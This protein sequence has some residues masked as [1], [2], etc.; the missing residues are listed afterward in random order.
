M[1]L[2]LPLLYRECTKQKWLLSGPL[3][4]AVVLGI[5]FFLAS[6]QG[7]LANNV[8]LTM[9][10]SGD[11]DLT[12]LGYGASPESVAISVAGMLS[13]T[14]SFL[15]LAKALLTATRLEQ[16]DP[17][18]AVRLHLFKL[19]FAF[20]I[21]P[22]SCLPLLG[23][24]HYLFWQLAAFV[25]NIEPVSLFQQTV[26]MFGHYMERMFLAGLLALPIGL[27]VLCVSQRTSAPLILLL[28]LAYSIKWLSPM[29]LGTEWFSRYVSLVMSAPSDVISGSSVTHALAEFGA[30][31][32][33][34]YVLMGAIAAWLSVRR[35]Q[36]KEQCAV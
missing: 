36:F 33:S 5:F 7:Q 21:I 1:K 9:N 15:Y 24:M 2:M 10:Y 12:N 14:L 16:E 27:L 32:G 4:L 23:V 35:L 31:Y 26:F 34:L 19:L 3:F 28:V 17:K 18:M 13:L 25:G 6:T 22:L 11:F 8:T 29:L 30:V 20:I